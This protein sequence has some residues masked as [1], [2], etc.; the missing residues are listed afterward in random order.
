MT[1][2]QNAILFL[3]L[4][5]IFVQFYFSGA[6]KFAWTQVI[7]GGANSGGPSTTSLIP[8]SS[9]SPPPSAKGGRPIVQ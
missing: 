9:K 4:T 3:G 6:L 1:G 8:Q 2:K 7:S 5:L